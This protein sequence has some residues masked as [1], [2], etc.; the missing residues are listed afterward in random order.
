MVIMI[1]NHLF[2]IIHKIL[3]IFMFTIP[4]YLENCSLSSPST[5][6]DGG[7]GEQVRG[8]DNTINLFST[9]RYLSSCWWSWSWEGVWGWCWCYWWWLG[10]WRWWGGAWRCLVF[11]HC[12]KEEEKWNWR[13]CLWILALLTWRYWTIWEWTDFAFSLVEIFTTNFFELFMYYNK[14]SPRAKSHTHHSFNQM[15]LISS[16]SLESDIILYNDDQW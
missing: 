2:I 12:K 8:K 1:I 15:I 13:K 14:T 3:T 4:I 9:K 10:R 11:F 5:L 6:L 16:A 7:E